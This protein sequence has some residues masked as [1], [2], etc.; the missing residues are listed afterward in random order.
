VSKR[1]GF[2]L[3]ELMLALAILGGSLAILSRI[4]D[5]GVSAAI[6]SRS[7]AQARMACQAKLSELLLDAASGIQPQA[8][9]SVPIEPFDSSSTSPMNYSV[10][11]GAAPIDG[12]LMIRVT[13]Q[14]QNDSASASLA[15][16][17]LTRWLVDPALGLEAAEAEEKAAL[18][19]D[20]DEGV[21]E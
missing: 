14:V 10:D 21:I 17:S 11:V 20:T 19:G 16:C 5:T 18:E 6:E 8:V 7:L 12:L 2:S 15:S 9:V 4:V 3:L 13:V 1:D